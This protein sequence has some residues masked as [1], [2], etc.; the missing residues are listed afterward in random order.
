MT[1][2]IALLLAL[3]VIAIILFLFEWVPTDVVALSL[4]VTLVLT[5][6]LPSKQAFS[7]FGS[8]TVIMILGL[9]IMTA[10]LART[11]VVDLIGRS[12]L[13]YT[14]ADPT[15]LLLVV[16][17]AS[18]VLSAFMSNT[19]STAFFVPIVIGI[20]AKAK[21]PASKFLMPLAF[22]SILTSSVTLISTSTNLVISGL[23]TSY[24]L[25]P[26]GMFELAPVGIPIAMAGLLYMFFIGRRLLP[27]RSNPTELIEEFGLRPYLS[28]LLILPDSPLIDKTLSES[29]LG[30]HLD[31]AVLRIVRDK[32]QYLAPRA[33]TRLAAHDLLLVEGTREDV[34]KI[35]DTA[36]IE[37]KADVK[38][39]DPNLESEDTALVEVILLPGSSLIGRTLKNY[40]F[41]ERYGLQVLGMNRH[42]TNVRRKMSQIPFRMGD[43]L[44]LQGHRANIA[45]LEEDK[46][47]RILGAVTEKRPNRKQALMAVSI[48]AGAVLLATFKVISLPIAFLIGTIFT[49]LTR[50]ITP[51]EAYREVE[52]KAIILIASM[53]GLGVAMEST[54]AAKY[55]AGLL[56]QMSSQSEPVWLLGGF[57]GLTVILTQPCRIKPQRRSFFPSPS[58]RRC[59]SG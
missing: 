29:G 19:A 49:F 13:R 17:I 18:A 44:L 47:F 25:P 15:H 59:S 58:R 10:S 37:I 42:G 1:F 23:M 22:S 39:A 53:L 40:R 11:G 30:Q 33:S 3:I 48:F 52:W 50:C 51:E 32:G 24:N 54:G 28:E 56:V 45:E 8:D 16:M 14:G 41:R 20:A 36:G 12:I 2:S 27:N 43:V 46:T 55:L 34:L 9:L 57:F 4:L 21:M 5:G 26:M 35:K 31:L 6:L 38:L 7:G